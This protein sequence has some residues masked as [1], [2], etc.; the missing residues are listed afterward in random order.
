MAGISTGAQISS[1]LANCGTDRATDILFDGKSTDVHS[2]NFAI[3][4]GEALV[5]SAFG[6]HPPEQATVEKLRYAAA[7]MPQ[8]TGCEG[9]ICQP[10][11]QTATEDVTH[12]GVWSLH[13]CQNIAVLTVPGLYR[14]R[15][16]ES[17]VGTAYIDKTLLTTEQVKSIPT[18]L[19]F[20][21]KTGSCPPCE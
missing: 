8:G 16:T 1:N 12:C 13:A 15:L 20:G 18:E 6:L 4:P 14:L 3:A 10:S 19:F 11:T 2:Q 7:Q 5:L 21:S 9:A 17:A